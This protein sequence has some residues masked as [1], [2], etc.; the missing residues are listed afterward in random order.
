MR[1]IAAHAGVAPITVS[2][3]LSDPTKVNPSTL[4]RIMEVVEREGFIPDNVAGSMRTPSKV[5]G[6]IVRR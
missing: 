5:I 2:R 4:K 3:A 1:D 6:T